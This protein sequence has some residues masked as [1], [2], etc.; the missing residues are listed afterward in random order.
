MATCLLPRAGSGLF[1]GEVLVPVPRSPPLR[2]ADPYSCHLHLCI[3]RPGQSSLQVGLRNR[4]VWLRGDLSGRDLG[5]A[6][7]TRS[8]NCSHG[9]HAP[10]QAVWNLWKPTAQF[11]DPNDVP[12]R[13]QPMR[14]SRNGR[15]SD[16][17]GKNP[18]RGFRQLMFQ[19][20]GLGKSLPVLFH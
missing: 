19:E 10:Q 14:L 11:L 3:W 8:V 9:S 13:A 5:A 16:V 7:P 18:R 2:A 4:L 1:P 17:S 20:Q 15:L 6:L 12:G